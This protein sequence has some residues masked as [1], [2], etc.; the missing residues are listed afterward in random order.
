MG[1]SAKGPRPGV[2][3]FVIRIDPKPL[4]FLKSLKG[5][6]QKRIEAAITLLATNPIPP[7]ALK[8]SNREGYRLRIGNYRVIYSI[9]REI[10]T[11]RVI[12]IGHRKEIYR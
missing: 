8:L 6:D 12:D 9:K 7:K 2:S 10:L 4:K 11:I 5:P 1:K 3:N